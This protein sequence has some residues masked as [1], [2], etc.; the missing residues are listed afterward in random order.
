[1]LVTG[2]GP[3]GCV[4]AELATRSRNGECAQDLQQAAG[5][6]NPLLVQLTHQLNSELG[7][8]VFI[9]AD[10]F[11]MNMNFITNPQ[12][13][14][15]VTSKIACCGQ[16]PYNGLGLCTPISNLCADRDVYVFW[17]AFHPSERALRF[18]VQQIMTGSSQYMSPMNLTTLIG[19]VDSKL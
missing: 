14:G 8:D 15:F 11:S 2:T 5:I 6:F 12:D 19:L 3:L 4:P 10:A 13:Y 18:I 7:S 17:D 1:M 9:S 16:G